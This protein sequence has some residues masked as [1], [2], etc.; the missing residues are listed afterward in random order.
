MGLQ[1]VTLE[2]TFLHLWQQQQ[3]QLA[4]GTPPQAKLCQVTVEEE[5]QATQKPI[6]GIGFEATEE[7][8]LIFIEA[9][10]IRGSIEPEDLDTQQP[11]IARTINKRVQ[12]SIL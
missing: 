7:E 10:H 9:I 12:T 2:R 3:Q 11:F 5:G 8:T 6:K 4:T 1:T